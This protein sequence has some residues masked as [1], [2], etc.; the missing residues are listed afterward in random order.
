MNETTTL[1]SNSQKTSTSTSTSTITSTSTTNTTNNSDPE[2]FSN[3][4]PTATVSSASLDDMNND[5]GAHSE[6]TFQASTTSVSSLHNFRPSYP[7]NMMSTN[8]VPEFLYQLT[9][10]LTENNRGII[11]WSEGTFVCVLREFCAIHCAC[12]AEV[13]VLIDAYS[14]PLSISNPRNTLLHG[15]NRSNR[16][17]RSVQARNRGSP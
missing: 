8:N 4:K 10:M 1:P 11:E 5:T 13:K 3:R 17:A 16:S 14:R 9:K 7:S 15:A 12:H 2:L 6:A